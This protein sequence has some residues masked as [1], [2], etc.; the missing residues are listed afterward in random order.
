[1]ETVRV[2]RRAPVMVVT[3]DRP[4]VRNAVDR[5]TAT[6]L[7]GAF[8]DFESEDDMSVAILTGSGE[9]FC[10]G[11]D[12]KA[13]ASGDPGRANRIEPEGDGPMGPTRQV[14]SKPVIAAVEGYAVAGG[15]ELV[16]WC[17]L[18]IAAHDAIFGVF[19]RRWGVPLI[20]GGTIRLTRAIG[21]S[22]ALEMIL[23]GRAV[24]ADEAFAWGLVNQVVERG[25]ALAEAE[26]LAR[27]IAS[28]PQMS[29]RADRTSAREQWG[30]PLAE[31]L[32]REF[33]GGMRAVQGGEAV[34]GARRFDSPDS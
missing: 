33:A 13:I 31:A 2:E 32:A 18:C 19:N 17:D 20:D 11:A 30:R 9:T 16:L 8:R 4:E 5:A 6:Q 25:D 27:H 34:A 7:A 24:G 21:Q 10:A 12:L 26:A 22:R 29:L 15:L 23:T 28:W 14:L 1:M 3:I